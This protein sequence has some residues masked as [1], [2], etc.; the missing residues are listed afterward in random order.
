[1]FIVQDARGC[2]GDDF[3]WYR[4][5]HIAIDAKTTGTHFKGEVSA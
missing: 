5:W 1:M 2:M 3:L 4:W